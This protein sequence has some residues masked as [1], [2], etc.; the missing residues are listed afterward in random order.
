MVAVPVAASVEVVEATEE[1][2][3]APSNCFPADKTALNKL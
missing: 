3:D 1:R 2:L